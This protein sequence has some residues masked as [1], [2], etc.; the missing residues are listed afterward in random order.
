MSGIIRVLSGG[1]TKAAFASLIPQFE[2]E[3]SYK[4]NVD[5][6][7]TAA[8]DEKIAAGEPVDVLIQPNAVLDRMQNAGVTLSDKRANLGTVG[9]SV[10]VPKGSARI[11]ISTPERFTQ[12]LRE[13]R[14]VVHA[15]PGVTPSGTHL[16]KLMETLGIAQEMARKTI[17]RPALEGGV[18]T[19]GRGEADLG[20]YPTSEV[21]NIGG[22]DVVGSLPEPLNLI[23][24]VGA[25]LAA[26]CVQPVPSAALIAFLA[27]G[28]GR[29]GWID[30]GFVPAN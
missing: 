30:G 24:M 26:R 1:A 22:I 18:E 17:H 4:V 3:A 29:A 11:D 6:L 14:S 21:V 10:I 25:A 15:T 19:V 8:I 7:V 12:A 20:I 23:V 13:A 27:S 2:N 5:Y 16:G 28:K 9:L